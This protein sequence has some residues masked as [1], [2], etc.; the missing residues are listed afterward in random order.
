MQKQLSPLVRE[1]CLEAALNDA[2]RVKE[3]GPRDYSAKSSYQGV[4]RDPQSLRESQR[5]LTEMSQAS[6][7]RESLAIEALIARY[8]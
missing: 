2:R 4:A 6:N 7:L 1:V 3:R 5:F 8:L